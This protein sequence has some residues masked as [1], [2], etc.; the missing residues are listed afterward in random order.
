MRP[1]Y[2]RPAVKVS[3]HRDKPQTRKQE[4]AQG[5]VTGRLPDP[6]AQLHGSFRWQVPQHF[7]IAQACCGRW[8]GW[9]NDTNNIAIYAYS[10]L[11]RSL[12]PSDRPERTRPTADCASFSYAQLQRDA[13]RFSNVLK[14][15][16]VQRGDCV[17]I[18]MPQRFETAVAYIA[19]LQMGAVAMPLS[20]LF[21][22]EALEYR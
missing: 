10:T 3:Q 15:C 9:P 11:A 20:M 22:P 1:S 17:A 6:Y 4:P 13:N 14:A 2:E 21:G 16:G 7:N 5:H 18:V 8:A 12:K 19:V